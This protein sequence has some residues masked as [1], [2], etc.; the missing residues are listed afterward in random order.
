MKKVIPRIRAIVGEELSCS[1]HNLEHVDRVLRLCEYLAEGES[2]VDR[3]V[4][5][6]AAL[7]HDIA[8]VQ[9]DRDTSGRIDHAVTGAAMAEK[10]LEDLG[11]ARDKT[12]AIVHCILTHRF[13]TGNPPQS[14][15]AKILFDA[16]KLDVVGA[17]GLARSYAIAGQYGE[18]FYADVSMEAYLRENIEG[19][20]PTGRIKDIS[21]H[22]TNLEFDLKLQHIPDKLFTEKAKT[23][24]QARVDFMRLF[25]DRLK[26]E[27]HGEA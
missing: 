11:V 12:D 6:A 20:V 25:F 7:L 8:R 21:K 22:A 2:G 3:D 4:L 13:R 27:I 18:P 9:E 10:I 23:L 15:E 14:R 1:A 16:D 26:Q 24:A 19:G 5:A 17:I